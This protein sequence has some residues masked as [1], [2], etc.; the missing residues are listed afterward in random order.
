MPNAH[1]FDGADEVARDLELR[2]VQDFFTEGVHPEVDMKT[3]QV[4]DILD[5][6]SEDINVFGHCILIRD[7]AEPLRVGS[8][9]VSKKAKALRGWLASTKLGKP[10]SGDKG[11]ED[12]DESG[13]E[14]AEQEDGD[15]KKGSEDGDKEGKELLFQR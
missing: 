15:D 7:Y 6:F 12:E 4:H 14:G 13:E 8:G 10:H 11:E 1:M 9:L 2:G 5:I 3:N